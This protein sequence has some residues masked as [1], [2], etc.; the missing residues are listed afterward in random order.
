MINPAPG[1][2]LA[3]N[4]GGSQGDTGQGDTGGTGQG[5][6]QPLPGQLIVPG[7]PQQSSTD[8]KKG[9]QCMTTCAQW[10]EECIL[11]NQGAGGMQRRCRH[12]CKQFTEEC[13]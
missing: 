7:S 5:S 1:V 9:K 13:Y 6:G 10:G 4:T 12:V 3:A 11:V 2:V 8:K